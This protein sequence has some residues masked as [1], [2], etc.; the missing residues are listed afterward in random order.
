MAIRMHG[1]EYREAE[2]MLPAHLHDMLYFLARDY[3]RAYEK[4]LGH[5]AKPKASY[6]I[7]AELLLQG[8]QHSS[9]RD[10]KLDLESLL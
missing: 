8:W 3:L 7:L 9:P 4:H 10:D 5:D 1:E 2:A 6:Q